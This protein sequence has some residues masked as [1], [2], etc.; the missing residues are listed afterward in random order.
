VTQ[1]AGVPIRPWSSPLH[2]SRAAARDIVLVLFVLLPSA[3]AERVVMQA[4]ESFT[5]PEPYGATEESYA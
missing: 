5:I 4:S 3:R 1:L 2:R